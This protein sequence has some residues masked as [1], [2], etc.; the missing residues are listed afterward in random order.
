MKIHV[1]EVK[2]ILNKLVKA[3]VRRLITEEKVR[4]DGRKPD[5]IRP[6]SS[7]VGLTRT[8]TWIRIVYTWT[9]SS[10]FHLYIRCTRRCTDSG[11]S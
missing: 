11:W 3:E 2:E 7:E 6:L 8:H 5:E 9:N 10:S 4:P 1:K